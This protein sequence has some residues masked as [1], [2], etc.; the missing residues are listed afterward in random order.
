MA[1]WAV[2]EEVE[3]AVDIPSLAVAAGVAC[4]FVVEGTFVAEDIPYQELHY[5][6]AEEACQVAYCRL[7][8]ASN[9][10]ASEAVVD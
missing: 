2:V 5:I 7:V 4:T 3:A 1:S 9:Q 8:V 10:A 6:E